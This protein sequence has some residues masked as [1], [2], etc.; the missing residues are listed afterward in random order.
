MR[1]PPASQRFSATLTPVWAEELTRRDQ[2][3]PLATRRPRAR[4]IL[5][6]TTPRLAATV[7]WKQSDNNYFTTNIL[8][9]DRNIDSN[10]VV[11]F[12]W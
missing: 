2:S 11:F 5:C 10:V 8:I 4:L 1:R 9:K 6:T 7:I 12:F 3:S